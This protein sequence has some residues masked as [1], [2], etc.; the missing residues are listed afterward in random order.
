M[1][2][3][4][5]AFISERA[6]IT[7]VDFL[8]DELPISKSKIKEAMQKGA[9]WLKRG[10]DEPV[11]LRRAKEFIK[12]NDEVHIYYDP[13]FLKAKTPE[14]SLIEDCGA[15]SVWHK[16]AGILTEQSL[17][18][19]HLNLEY[20]VDSSVDKERD[21]HW[22]F[23][24]QIPSTGLLLM[25]HSRNIAARFEE[26]ELQDA[27]DVL[28]KVERPKAEAVIDSHD[29]FLIEHESADLR[30][31]T[32]NRRQYYFKHGQGK[33]LDIIEAFATRVDQRLLEEFPVEL[34]CEAMRFSCPKT[35]TIKRF[36]LS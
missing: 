31:E 35:Q 6:G 26:Q 19:D 16:P 36:S 28:Y 14:L 22:I 29:E 30:Q 15:Y 9:V 34:H 7:V 33:E 13:V 12:L 3:I 27:I 25:A 8:A 24:N 10:D 21:C 11:R 18:G 23:P 4:E 2:I 1:S 20:V 17:F 32:H 5:R